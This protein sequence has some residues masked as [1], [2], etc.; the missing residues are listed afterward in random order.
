MSGRL[1]KLEDLVWNAKWPEDVV[2]DG[3]VL[4]TP[5]DGFS[6]LYNMNMLVGWE[7]GITLEGHRW[8]EEEVKLA[9]TLVIFPTKVAKSIHRNI[10]RLYKDAASVT[11]YPH[12]RVD[13]SKDI[14]HLEKTIEDRFYRLPKDKKYILAFT[15]F[16]YGTMVARD[17]MIER[18]VDYRLLIFDS[19]SHQHHEIED[20]VG[21]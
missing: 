5:D 12:E 20:M 15:G 17:F 3:K 10:M 2:V 19:Y 14:A 18:G 9:T 21:A 13:V 16:C 4:W 6:D 1:S 11:L 8:V 7:T